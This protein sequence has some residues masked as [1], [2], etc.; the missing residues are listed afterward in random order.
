MPQTCGSCNLFLKWRAAPASARLPCGSTLLSGLPPS[1]EQGAIYTHRDGL[2]TCCL[3]DVACA[4]AWFPPWILLCKHHFLMR[5]CACSN[6]NSLQ[7]HEQACSLHDE[8]ISLAA[9]AEL[10]ARSSALK[11]EEVHTPNRATTCRGKPALECT[12]MKQPRQLI[13]PGTSSIADHT[14]DRRQYVNTR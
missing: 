10:F 9:F 14:R 11:S 7:A 6:A 4:S 2:Q 8:T 3:S 1:V 5:I 12:S 13:G